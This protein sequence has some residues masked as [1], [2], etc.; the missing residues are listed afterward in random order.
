M[1]GREGMATKDG[2]T[3]AKGKC[4][5][6]MRRTETKDDWD[7]L[8]RFQSTCRAIGTSISLGAYSLDSS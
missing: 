5:G 6:Q 1:D 2:R 4:E 3:N 8:L 7:T